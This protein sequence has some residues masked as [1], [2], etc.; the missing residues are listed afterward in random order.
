MSRRICLNAASLDPGSADLANPLWPDQTE[1][2]HH[3]H[4]RQP[5]PYGMAL[6]KDKNAPA[7]P[8]QRYK[9][10]GLARKDRPGLLDEAEEC[11]I[12]EGVDDAQP[13][14]GNRYRRPRQRK[15]PQAACR[16]SEGSHHQ[17]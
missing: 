17:T 2:Y 13:K 9:I 14:K 15:C 6:A 16:G 12:G 8:K 7:N 11:R 10:A 1:R 3:G 5:D 4:K